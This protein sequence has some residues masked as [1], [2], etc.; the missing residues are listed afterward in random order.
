[1][2]KPKNNITNPERWNIQFEVNYLKYNGTATRMSNAQ[3]IFYRVNYAWDNSP[4]YIYTG[5]FFPGKKEVTMQI[6]TQWTCNTPDIEGK[7][8]S[9]I[10]SAIEK[11]LKEINHPLF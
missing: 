7:F 4:N 3:G 8:I 6:F 11:V 10:G 9:P 1:M 2:S 5:N